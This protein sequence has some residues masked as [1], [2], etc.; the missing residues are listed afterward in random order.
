MNR[1]I[2]AACAIA[3]SMIAAGPMTAAS[4]DFII[5]DTTHNHGLTAGPYAY[6][7]TLIPS[8]IEDSEIG[9]AVGPTTASASIAGANQVD[10]ILS[11]DEISGTMTE[12]ATES[13]GYFEFMTNFGVDTDTD[14]TLSWDLNP[15]IDP[16]EREFLLRDVTNISLLFEYDYATHGDTG[17]VNIPLTQ[18]VQY[19]VETELRA[20][21]QTSTGFFKI[22]G[23]TCP[24]ADINGDGVVD[25]A[26]LGILI[27]Q[28]GDSCD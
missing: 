15:G 6:C 21:E 25:T 19:Y 11:T 10:V 2:R 9:A 28:F 12:G 3:A 27:E 18:G 22:A 5:I 26:D 14:I 17:S 1:T 24:S 7:Y 23:P 13:F 8:F 16:S 20:F 4:A